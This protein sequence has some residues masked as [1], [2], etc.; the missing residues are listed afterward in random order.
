[1]EFHLLKLA[2][3]LRRSIVNIC[4]DCEQFR[5]RVKEWNYYSGAINP[6][7][8]IDDMIKPH[9]HLIVEGQRSDGSGGHLFLLQCLKCDQ[10]WEL[11]TWPAVGQ[12]DVKPYVPEYHP[13]L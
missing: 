1:M 2:Q 8:Y 7:P 4:E 10:W 6:L 5:T 12:L 9:K 11:F 13:T 3:Y